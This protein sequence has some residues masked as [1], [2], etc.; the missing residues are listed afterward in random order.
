MKITN[1]TELRARLA[2]MMDMVNQNHEPLI[3]TRTGGKACVLMSLED[4][5]AFSETEYLLASPA[6]ARLLKES[7]AQI[8][9]GESEKH[10]LVEP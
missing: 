5:N 4:F 1:S 7:I 2:A 8:E 9:K 6:N 3:I 10:D